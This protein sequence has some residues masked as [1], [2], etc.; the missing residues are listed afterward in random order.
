MHKKTNLFGLVLPLLILACALAAYSISNKE[1]SDIPTEQPSPDES[2]ETSMNAFLAEALHY[3]PSDNWREVDDFLLL[4]NGN[5]W[6]LTRPIGEKRDTHEINPCAER[7]SCPVQNWIV[8]PAT[9]ESHLVSEQNSYLALVRTLP[10]EWPDGTLK[11]FWSVSV[12]GTTLQSGDRTE[13]VNKETGELISTQKAENYGKQVSVSDYG[14]AADTCEQSGGVYISR[15]CMCPNL[16][17]GTDQINIDPATGFCLTDA[18]DPLNA[19]Q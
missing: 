19:G 9:G 8:N 13:I 7:N 2:T 11:V 10:V 16:I 17:P 5:V 1:I 15:E 12:G 4:S 14:P 6:I 18:G 3:L